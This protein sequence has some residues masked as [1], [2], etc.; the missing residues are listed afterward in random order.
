MYPQRELSRLASHKAVLRRRITVRR[1]ETVGLA[2]HVLRPVAW[3]D[4]LLALV[5]RLSPLAAFAAIPLGL[6]LKRPST[7]RPSLFGKLLRWAPLVL[8]AVRGLAARR[9]R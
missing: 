3:L 5:R 9:T 1:T 6:L 2:T 4:S 8:A 7:P